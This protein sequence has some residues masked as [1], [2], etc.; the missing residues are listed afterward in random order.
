MKPVKNFLKKIKEFQSINIFSCHGVKFFTLPYQDRDKG[1]YVDSVE[2]RN[3]VTIIVTDE[4]AL[5]DSENYK[6]NF[7]QCSVHWEDQLMY[8]NFISKKTGLINVYKHYPFTP[9]NFESFQE[10]QAYVFDRIT[11]KGFWEDYIKP[12]E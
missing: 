1:K 3:G 2:Y 7:I 12:I 4:P 6:P 8:L 9:K 5:T 11:E 10:F